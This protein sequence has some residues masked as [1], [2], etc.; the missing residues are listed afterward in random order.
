MSK[1]EILIRLGVF[2]FL[3]GMF[4]PILTILTGIE[5]VSA[6][7]MGIGVIMAIFLVN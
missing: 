7:L 6:I 2:L 1:K 5:L 4:L 3:L